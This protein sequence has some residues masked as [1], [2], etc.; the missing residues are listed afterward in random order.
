MAVGLAC[1]LFYSIAA[2]GQ[3]LPPTAKASHVSILK[4]PSLETAVNDLAILTWTVNN[5]GGLD[6]HYAV[7]YYGTDP[8]HL[9][10]MAKSHIR[11]NREHPETV[12]RV[13]MMG[14]K[15]NTTYYYKVSSIESNGVS[16]GVWS[17]VKQ[18]RTPG[19]GQRISP[20]T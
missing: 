3:I 19:P 11:L 12:F 16:D 5:P 15:P 20:A 13:R 17:A 6:D 9:D 8:R 14:L 1:G 10:T 18:F 7:V 2:F 4:G